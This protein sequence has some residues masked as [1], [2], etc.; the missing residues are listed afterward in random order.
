METF[1]LRP[2]LQVGGRAG[3]GVEDEVVHVG[4]VF[5]GDEWLELLGRGKGTCPG[6]MLK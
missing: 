1:M 4:C 6:I 5:L 3:A 2:L